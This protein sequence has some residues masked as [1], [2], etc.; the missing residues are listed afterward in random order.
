MKIRL[1]INND[2]GDREAVIVALAKNG[3]SVTSEMVELPNDSGND[4]IVEFEYEGAID[5]RLPSSNK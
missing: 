4:F 5:M 2:C 1:K 3:Y